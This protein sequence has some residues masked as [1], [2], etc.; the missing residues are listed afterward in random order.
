MN[1]TLNCAGCG[2]KFEATDPQRWSH[3]KGN[4]VFCGEVCVNA[5]KSNTMASTNRKYASARMVANNPMARPESLKKMK[6]TLKRIG[7]KPTVR[8]GNGTGLSP[9]E[10]VLAKA[11]GLSPYVVPTHRSRNSGYP[12]HYK[13]DLADPQRLLAIEVDGNSHGLLARQAQDRKKEGLLR[14]LGWTV[15][16]FTNK[17]ALE[18]TQMCMEKIKKGT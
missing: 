12:T 1:R 16:R 10:L 5:N 9:A 2:N 8:G 15:I 4:N 3:N 7:H 18:E 13:L 11:T 17:Q 6:R 14:E